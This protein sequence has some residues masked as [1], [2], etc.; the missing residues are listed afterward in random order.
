MNNVFAGLNGGRTVSGHSISPFESDSDHNGTTPRK[1]NK[2]LHRRNAFSK[3]P[4]IIMLTYKRA[5]IGPMHP[6]I[7]LM[8]W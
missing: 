4:S 7:S 1:R 8:R 5:R 3:N 2:L 6:G